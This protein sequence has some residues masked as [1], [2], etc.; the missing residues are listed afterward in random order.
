[1]KSGEIKLHDIGHGLSKFEDQILKE[2]GYFGAFSCTCMECMYWVPLH[3]SS[4]RNYTK[5]HIDTH[6]VNEHCSK[7]RQGG[8]LP[9]LLR[10]LSL[11]CLLSQRNHSKKSLAQLSKP[12]WAIVVLSFWD[13]SHWWDNLRL[14]RLIDVWSF[15][16]WG[17]ILF[18]T[19]L[20]I[21][22]SRGEYLTR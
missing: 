11:P 19:C 14:M 20:H 12:P 13:L 17:N 4:L 3:I 10:W 15:W 18:A 9:M 22:D 5:L 6:Q 2:G 16:R 1:M 7:M 21:V 8:E